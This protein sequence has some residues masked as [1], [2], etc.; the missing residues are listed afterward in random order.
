MTFPTLPKRL[1]GVN[2]KMYFDAPATT[3]YIKAVSKFAPPA[4]APCEI[5]II[6]SFPCLGSASDLLRSTPQVIIGAQDCHQDD[7]GAHT[8]SVSAVM[9]KQLGCA[10]VVLG[11]AERRAAPFNE[12]DEDV[13]MKANAVVRNGMIP[14]VCIGEKAKSA[15]MSEGVGLAVKECGIQ[16]DSVLAAIPQDV[17]VV[18]AYEPVWAIGATE[19]AGE[20]HTLAVV[21]ALK[22]ALS[23]NEEKRE[24]RFLYGG[25]AKPGLWRSLKSELDGL[26]LGRFAHD[27]GNFEQVVKEVM[28]S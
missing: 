22:N 23:S 19:P 10:M 17:P 24:A 3:S 15:I 8:G 9:L 4:S 18:F 6:P 28:E 13:A 5:F 20:D 12:T 7:N 2:L 14:L 21:K 25:S 16:M 1:V 27:V 11:H 26:F